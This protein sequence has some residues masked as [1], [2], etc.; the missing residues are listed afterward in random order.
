MI[1][2]HSG[3]FNCSTIDVRS[4]NSTTS[5]GRRFSIS[6]IYAANGRDAP[7][8]IG[9]S[10]CARYSSRA[11]TDA[12]MRSAAAQPSVFA[13]SARS[14]VAFSLPGHSRSTK[15]RVSSK[16][17][18][19]VDASISS[20][21]FRARKRASGSAA[22]ARVQ[23]TTCTCAGACSMKYVMTSRTTGRLIR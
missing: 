16:L 9:A 20:S 23:I 5:S 1:A 7:D 3:A 14:E 10:V 18:R 4:M 22:S 12:E 2:S 15:E 13:K 6:S 21:S 11:S 19:S 8:G 17:K